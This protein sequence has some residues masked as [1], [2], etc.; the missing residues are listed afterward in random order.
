VQNRGKKPSGRTGR[1]KS[2]REEKDANLDC[3]AKT[4][5]CMIRGGGGLL[6]KGKAIGT[7]WRSG[8]A[9]LATKEEKGTSSQQTG[10]RRPAPRGRPMG[11]NRSSLGRKGSG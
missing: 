10:K 8:L 2:P 1:E 9:D 11:G 7:T 3:G 6:E 4:T 5:D